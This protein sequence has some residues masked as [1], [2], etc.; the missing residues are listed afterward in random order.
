MLLADVKTARGAIDPPF[1]AGTPAPAIALPTLDHGARSLA[2]AAGRVVVVHF[3]ATWCEP[4]RDEM[5]GLSR[6][7]R[8]MEG[9][10]FAILA[11]DVGEVE[12]R[13]RRFFEAAPVPF[14]ILLDESRAAMKA[15]KVDA[16]PSTFVLDGTHA[17]RLFAAGPVDWDDPAVDRILGRLMDGAA[18]AS[19][20]V[21][22]PEHTETGSQPQ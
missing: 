12:V 4:C 6:L 15:W 13:V 11:I 16:F 14:P 21:L 1:P 2:D 7:S 18:P 17:I 22:P 20:D 8:R 3:F 10:R 19:N 9:R 5:A